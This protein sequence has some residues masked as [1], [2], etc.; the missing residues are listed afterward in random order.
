MLYSN[1]SLTILLMPGVFLRTYCM[2]YRKEQVHDNRLML[3]LN[4]ILFCMSGIHV[5]K[6]GEDQSIKSGQSN[7]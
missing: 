7:V 3:T 6:L 2:S 5:V 1:P 4:I